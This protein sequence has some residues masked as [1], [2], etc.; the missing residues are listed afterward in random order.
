MQV[1]ALV[2]Q[3]LSEQRHSRV[4]KITLFGLTIFTAMLL[5]CMFGLTWAVVAAL[6]DTDVSTCGQKHPPGCPCS[7]LAHGKLLRCAV[8]CL[9][10]PCCAV[11]H[12]YV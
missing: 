11:L 4:I 7:L 1:T 10:V 9:A 2:E 3:M 12:T 6:K 5:A 8:L